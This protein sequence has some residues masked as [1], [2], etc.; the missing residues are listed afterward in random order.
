MIIANWTT[1]HAAPSVDARLTLAGR[2]PLP[3]AVHMK[4][5]RSPS[6]TMVYSVLVPIRSLTLWKAASLDR[7]LAQAP[8][9]PPCRHCRAAPVRLSLG[10]AMQRPANH[11]GA[12]AIIDPRAHPG[13]GA[14]FV[15]PASPSAACRSRQ[16]PAFCREMPMTSASCSRCTASSMIGDARLK[17]GSAIQRLI[18][19]MTWGGQHQV[20]ATRQ[21]KDSANDAGPALIGGPDVRE[22]AAQ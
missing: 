13:R 1:A 20:P 21:V 15:M 10:F 7:L 18:C 5:S 9:P 3:E 22:R 17:P 12:L 19:S 11:G 2:M 4:A 14:S 8:S 6:C 16:R